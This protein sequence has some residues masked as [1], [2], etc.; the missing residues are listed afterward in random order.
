MAQKFLLVDDEADI[1][2]ILIFNL[3]EL[4]PKCEANQ[5]GNGVEAL[6]LTRKNKYD[7]IYTDF[8]MPM[9]DGAEF[10]KK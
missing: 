7:V 2:D 1:R 10:I 8:K 3:K 5:A 9:M 4:Y 6:E